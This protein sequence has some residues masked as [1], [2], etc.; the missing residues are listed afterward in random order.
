[1]GASSY[2]AVVAV[3]LCR[4]S[5]KKGGAARPVVSR[6]SSRTR[7]PGPS[8]TLS[9]PRRWPRGAATTLI[10]SSPRSTRNG[11]LATPPPMPAGARPPPG[12]RGRRQHWQRQPF[13][14]RRRKK[15]GS[16]ASAWRRPDKTATVAL[17]PSPTRGRH[18]RQTTMAGRLG[19]QS[20]V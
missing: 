3:P 14:P 19:R 13:A 18:R 15:T 9:P 5:P 11:C 12:H 1:M 8:T 2:T 7:R 10:G 20:N 6:S 16:F 4:R 17:R